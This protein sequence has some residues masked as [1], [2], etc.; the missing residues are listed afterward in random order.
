MICNCD[1]V[2]LRRKKFSDFE[3]V[4][5]TT[6]EEADKIFLAGYVVDDQGEKQNVRLFASSFFNA[7]FGIVIPELNSIDEYECVTVVGD[8]YNNKSVKVTTINYENNVEF[9]QI[10]KIAN[11]MFTTID[12][13]ECAL[14]KLS[15]NVPLGTVFRIYLPN[16]PFDKGILLFPSAD[17]SIT[18]DTPVEV[19][20]NPVYEDLSGVDFYFSLIQL[21]DTEKESLSLKTKV[22]DVLNV[23]AD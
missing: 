16:F 10:N 19:L 6:K 8:T 17:S 4:D 2:T 12:D 15:G 7:K 11:N 1:A 3:L 21:A 5:P 23:K 14:I 13:K 22:L 18:K 9:I 20:Y